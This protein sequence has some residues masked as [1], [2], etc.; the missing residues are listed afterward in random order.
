MNTAIALTAALLGLALY[1]Q[2]DC[3]LPTGWSNITIKNHNKNRR[4]LVYRP[5][6]KAST[7]KPALWMHLHGMKMAPEDFKNNAFHT[8]AETE[9]AGFIVAMP[10]GT[11]KYWDY[12]GTEDL[13]L[14]KATALNLQGRGCGDPQRTYLS[15]FSLGAWMSFYT[16][17]KL[18]GVFA[19]FAPSGFAKYG[20]DLGTCNNKAPVCH[21]GCSVSSATTETKTISWATVQCQYCQ[22]SGLET[23]V[24]VVNNQGH[25]WLTGSEQ[26]IWAFFKKFTLTSSDSESASLK[27][28]SH[29]S[30][31][32]KA[33][34]HKSESPKSSS[35]KDLE[36]FKIIPQ[37]GSDNVVPA[38]SGVGTLV[39]DFTEA[40]WSALEVQCWAVYS[41]LP[42]DD[43]GHVTTTKWDPVITMPQTMSGMGYVRVNDI[44]VL[45]GY[46]LQA[47]SYCVPQGQRVWASVGNVNFRL[48]PDQQH[49]TGSVTISRNLASPAVGPL[50]VSSDAVSFGFEISAHC[51]VPNAAMTCVSRSGNPEHFG[52]KWAD[53]YE[54]PMSRVEGAGADRWAGYARLPAA[55]QLLE[56]TARC[57]CGGVQAW[58]GGNYQITVY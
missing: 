57:T 23:D 14:F 55:G 43:Y 19:A 33:S 12:T 41:Y 34:S 29:K 39:S 15:G 13:D 22:G 17:C 11:N 31:S 16:L 27:S 9:G 48:A 44:P 47:T 51:T 32:H 54:R 49:P 56:I 26:Y 42:A 38:S 30:S 8:I 24:C 36:P 25:W 6:R 2:A 46:V 10:E 7:A 40:H 35:H 4:I 37:P 1:V 45:A 3:N 28:S 20:T 21:N 18:P 52:G 50:R 58:L 5:A 53:V